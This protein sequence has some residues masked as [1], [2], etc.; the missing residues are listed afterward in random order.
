[1]STI[2]NPGAGIP[3][4]LGFAFYS[5]GLLLTSQKIGRF[6]A[7][8]AGQFQQNFTGCKAS[9]DVAPT[10]NF[11][12]SIK[13]NGTTVGTITIGSGTTAGSFSSSAAVNIAVGD[14]IEVISNNSDATL[15]DFSCT[16]KSFST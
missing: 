2:G 13:Q 11:T 9:C 3:T 5:P 1:M 14:I 10:S 4:G 8:F 6:E 15:S 12:A 16:L 7:V